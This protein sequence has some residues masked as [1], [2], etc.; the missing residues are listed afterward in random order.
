ML[1]FQRIFR[2]ALRVFKSPIYRRELL[3]RF[4]QWADISSATVKVNG[5]KLCVNLKDPVLGKLLFINREYEAFESKLLLKLVRPG[6]NV[7]VL[8]ANIGLHAIPLSKAVGPTGKVIAFEPDPINCSF[9]KRNSKLSKTENLRV[10]EVAV[11][12]ID[13]ELTFYKSQANLS[14]HRSYLPNDEKDFNNGKEYIRI[15][16]PST[17]IDTYLSK[18]RISPDLI[19]MDIEGGEYH[20]FKGMTKTLDSCRCTLVLEVCPFF[21]KQAGAD[22]FVF[23]QEIIQKGFSL[24]KISEESSELTEVTPA[25]LLESIVA[26]GVVNL[27]A[28]R[29]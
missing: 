27:V 11:S 1:N 19:L 29:S 2:A 4:Y 20:A 25:V 12:N 21:L 22:P 26:K 28:L 5:T 8:G 15:N 23:L 7:L 18:H 13:G 14:N 17:T 6:M 16:V 10:E 3:Y 24:H 9:L